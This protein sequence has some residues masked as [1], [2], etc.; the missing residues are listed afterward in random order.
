MDI[1][2]SDGYDAKTD[3][4]LTDYVNLIE[5]LI[6]LGDNDDAIKEKINKILLDDTGA[7]PWKDCFQSRSI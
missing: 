5:R 7:G 6:S 4:L 3:G 2:F 1:K